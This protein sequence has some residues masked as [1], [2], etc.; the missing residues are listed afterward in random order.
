MQPFLPL[1]PSPLFHEKQRETKPA[2]LP[3]CFETG[4]LSLNPF[5]SGPLFRL[6]CS[7]RNKTFFFSSVTLFHE[8]QVFPEYRPS[9]KTDLPTSRK[10]GPFQVLFL[11]EQLFPRNVRAEGP[12]KGEG[13]RFSEKHR[14]SPFY[15]KRR[16][17]GPLRRCPDCRFCPDLLCGFLRG[18]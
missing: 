2:T 11:E 6:F 12:Q 1:A 7:M 16:P 17:I 18:L 15:F 9:R 14:P 3:A 5:L 4:S 13:R 10:H 8:K